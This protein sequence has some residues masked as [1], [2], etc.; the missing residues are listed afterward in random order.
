MSRLLGEQMGVNLLR[1]R[2]RGRE[3]GP[4]VLVIGGNPRSYSPYCLNA[5]GA[6]F[7]RENPCWATTLLVAHHS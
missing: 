6:S 3:Q 5:A 2:E 4:H 7:A 1:E